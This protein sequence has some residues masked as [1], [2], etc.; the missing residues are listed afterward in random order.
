MDGE[1]DAHVD[2]VLGEAVAVD[3]VLRLV[4]AVGDPAHGGGGHPLRVVE[5]LGHALLD[6]VGAVA[7]GEAHHLVAAGAQRADLRLDIALDVE[8][9]AGAALDDL[10]EL[11][12]ELALAHEHERRQ[13]QALAADVR[14]EVAADVRPVRAADGD[15]QQPP[16]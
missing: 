5:D 16:S 6:D 13:P 7:V 9:R 1:L 3:V 14:V 11:G 10:D 2:G 8:R 15:R 4:D 12:V